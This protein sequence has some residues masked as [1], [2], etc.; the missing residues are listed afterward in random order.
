[1]NDKVFTKPIKKQFEFDEEVA[2]VFDDMLQRSVPFYKES[3]KITEF[4]AHKALKNGGVA[5]DLGC[6]T[7]TLLINISRKLKTKATLIG[8]DNSEAML[9]QARRKCEAFKA[10]IELINAD[11]LEYEYKE[12]DLFVSNYT[13]QFIR[14]LI[15]EE[16]VKKIATSL[17]KDALFIFSEKVIS[18]HSKL[19][20]D[21]IECYYDFKKEQ[22][23]SEYEIV[24]KREALE[25]VLVP[26]SED[27]NI[28]MIKNCGFS[29]CEVIF[30]WAN[31]ATFIAIK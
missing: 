17:K 12:A 14:P 28:K 24:Q 19:N 9:E 26:Y 2:A 8:L 31:F 1:M 6:S 23:Y 15:R 29:H 11:I 4:F 22:G 21:L 16:L 3:Q 30:R 20:K 5:Y 27:E 13:L 18:H 25:N 10:D 7:A